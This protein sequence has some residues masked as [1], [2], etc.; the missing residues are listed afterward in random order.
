MLRTRLRDVLLGVFF[1]FVITASI[2]WIA[3]SWQGAL[4]ERDSPSRLMVWLAM[5]ALGAAVAA[6]LLSEKISATAKG[7]SGTLMLL[8]QSVISVPIFGTV[9]IG[10]PD[11]FRF[12]S[13]PTAYVIA[14]AFLAAAAHDYRQI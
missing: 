8:F 10:S 4:G 3:R 13:I 2:S 12:S 5:L 11:L 6:I 14:G 7:I 9:S 1:T